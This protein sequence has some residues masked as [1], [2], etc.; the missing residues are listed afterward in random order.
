[1]IALRPRPGAVPLRGRIR[2]VSG[3]RIS[4]CPQTRGI[5]IAGDRPKF[6]AAPLKPKSVFFIFQVVAIRD[7]AP[8]RLVGPVN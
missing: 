7:M 8:G 1:M 2:S 6:F 3:S 4:S 5:T